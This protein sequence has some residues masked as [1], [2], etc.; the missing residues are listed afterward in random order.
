[1]SE[2]K[3]AVAGASAK[4]AAHDRRGDFSYHVLRQDAEVLHNMAMIKF[5]EVVEA[6]EFVSA[7]PPFEHVAYLS[8]ANGET[9]YQSVAADLD[10]VPEGAEADPDLLEIPHKNDLD[11]GRNLVFEFSDAQGIETSRAVREIFCRKGAYGR[12]KHYLDRRGLLDQ[13]HEFEAG[14]TRR[15][16]LEWCHQMSLNVM[17]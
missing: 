16:L 4:G 13:W 8:K 12:F 11:L 14:E 1:M 3:V 10:E 7:A 17:E 2:G 9:F 15:R 5:S 6:F